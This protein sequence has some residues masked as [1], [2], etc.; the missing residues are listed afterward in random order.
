MDAWNNSAAWVIY[1]SVPAHQEN[2]GAGDVN[3]SSQP[4]DGETILYPCSGSGCSYST[5]QVYLNYYYT[6][7]YSDAKAQSPSAHEFGHVAGLAHTSSCVL[8]NPYTSGAYARWSSQC[9][10]INT[11]R[12]DDING[13]NAQY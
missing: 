11:P 2:L 1:T 13:V 4:W 12:S 5:G 6:Q 7:N 9:N 10:Y 8:M 3:D